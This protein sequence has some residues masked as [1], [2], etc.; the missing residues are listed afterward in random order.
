MNDNDCTLETKMYPKVTQIDEKL[1]YTSISRRDV[2]KAAII[3]EN[4]STLDALD[5]ARLIKPYAVL[6]DS[7]L[8]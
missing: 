4:P 6:S 8:I 1:I 3:I 2:R 5:L 7:C